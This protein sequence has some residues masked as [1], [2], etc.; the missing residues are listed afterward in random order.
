MARKL[1]LGWGMMCGAAVLLAGCQTGAGSRLANNSNNNKGPALAKQSTP[2][3]PQFPLANTPS[4]PGFGT[5]T[6]SGFPPPPN[7]PSNFQT[8]NGGFAT[9]NHVAPT[10]AT[11]NPPPQGPQGFGTPTAGN[12]SNVTISQPLTPPPQVQLA[13]PGIQPVLPELPQLPPIPPIPPTP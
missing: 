9:Q 11:N 7:M 1:G 12:R 10:G 6:G 3:Q 8:S 4:S 2:P 13:Q 5:A